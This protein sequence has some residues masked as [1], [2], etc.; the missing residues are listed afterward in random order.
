MTENHGVGGS[1]PPLG[2]ILFPKL[3]LRPE[4]ALRFA[5]DGL[6][7]GAQARSQPNTS[8]LN[9]RSEN[10][11]RDRGGHERKFLAFNPLLVEERVDRTQREAAVIPPLQLLPTGRFEFAQARVVGRR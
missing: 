10:D 11:H 1:I 7:S 4:P 6:T 8:P 2:T 3:G 5:Q 9:N